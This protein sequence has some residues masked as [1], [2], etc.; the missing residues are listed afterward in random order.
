MPVT[1]LGIIVVVTIFVL[2]G[3]VFWLRKRV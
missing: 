3:S 1:V 2:G